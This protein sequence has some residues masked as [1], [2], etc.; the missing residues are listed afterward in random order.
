[1]STTLCLCMIVRNESHVIRRALESVRDSIDYWV[2]CDTGSD[3]STVGEILSALAG[4]PG[5]LHGVTWENFGH[6][7]ADVLR[8]A[9]G[10]ADYILMMDADMVANINAPF[11][12]LLTADFY[13]IRYTGEV[14]YSQRMLIANGHDWTY[15]G[16]THEYIYA[17]T[18]EI[19]GCLPELTLTH[20]CD[21][22]MRFDKF[23]RDRRLLSAALAEDSENAR[24]AFY[25]AQTY[26]DLGRPLEAL[27]WYEKRIALAG[28]EEETWYA[29]FQAAQMRSLLGHEWSDVQQAFLRAYA[30]RPSRLEPLYEIV[31]H[32][33]EREEFALGYTFAAQVGHGVRYPDDKLFIEKPVYEYLFHLEYG[34]CAYGAGRIS[35]SIEAFNEVIRTESSPQWVRE[36]ARRGIE[37][38]VRDLYPVRAISAATLNRLVVVVPFHNPGHYLDE[39]V[40]SLLEQDYPNARVLFF[41]DASTDGSSE[42]LPPDDGRFTTFRSHF[43]RG[44]AYNLHFL[45]TEHCHPEDIVVCVD[46]D[47][48]LAVPDA[49]TH[50]NRCYNQHDCWVLYGQFQFANG[51]A[52]FSQPF[53]SPR[54]LCSARSYFRTSHLRTFRAGLFH[55]IADSDP[56]YT[57]LNDGAGQ[58]LESAVD[59][60]LMCPLIEMAGFDRVRFNPRVL[61][62]YND[63]A[64]SNHHCTNPA[65]QMSNFELV[66]DKRPFPRIGGY[67][68]V[69]RGHALSAEL[70]HDLVPGL[71]AAAVKGVRDGCPH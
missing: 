8:R 47:D 61:Y 43:R 26:R 27:K 33:R 69:S 55:R 24:N 3:D 68:S 59:A 37:I 56:F 4:I 17:P 16:I 48:R 63:C 23:E 29:R 70:V 5:E 25:L 44:T 64:P 15:V 18:A 36:A 45:I 10:K 28:W 49:L 62:I 11:K 9:R 58:W 2:I 54:D 21:G 42:R 65:K 22:G 66:R 1:M 57:C 67:R 40:L 20:L 31:K 38:A 35:E 12:H 39:C 32:Y 50:V 51:D 14:D 52:G 13:E 71:A 34:A 6:N 19:E 41:D 46:G 7:R 53:A 60:A 30:C